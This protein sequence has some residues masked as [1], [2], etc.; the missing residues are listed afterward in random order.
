VKA[1]IARHETPAQYQEAEPKPEAIRYRTYDE[2]PARYWK[3]CEGCYRRLQQPS[4]VESRL[5]R[6]QQEPLS[7]RRFS[8]TSAPSRFA[9]LSSTWTDLN[10]VKTD[11][12]PLA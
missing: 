10:T 7:E 9:R 12:Q 4:L 2:F 1:T 6:G 8:A 5:W 11:R 3:K